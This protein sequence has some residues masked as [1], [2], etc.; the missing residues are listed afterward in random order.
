[1]SM[2][3]ADGRFREKGSKVEP[4]GVSFVGDPGKTD[5]SQAEECDVNRIVDRFMKT[6]VLPGTDAQ[7]IYGDFSSPVDLQQ[8]LE[9]VNRAEE[10]F[11]SLTAQVR[12]RFNNDPAEFLAFCSD[13]GNGEEMVRLG[14]AERRAEGEVEADPVEAP[15]TRRS[16]QPRA[17]GGQGR[18][19]SP[20]GLPAKAKPGD[21]G[22]G[23]DA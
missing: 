12:K 14:L 21:A 20:A 5:Q 9:I 4:D 15:L 6:G 11:G 10:Q 3:A 7:A 2:L 16:G 13:P 1:M 18:P 19:P 23:G 22:E 17:S 8:A